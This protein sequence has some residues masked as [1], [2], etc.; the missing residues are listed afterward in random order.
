MDPTIDCIRHFAEPPEWDSGEMASIG[1]L[2]RSP[3]RQPLG[4]TVLESR[5]A[6]TPCWTYPRRKPHHPHPQNEAMKTNYAAH[7]AIYEA[8][9]AAGKP[10]WQEPQ[11]LRDTLA[12]L[13]ERMGSEHAPRSGRVLELGCGAGD[14]SLTLAEDGYE[15]HGVD[16]APTAI[17]W[18]RE[19]AAARC[20]SAHF[21]VGSVLEFAGLRE[22]FF[23][24]VLDGYCFHCIIGPDRARFLASARRAL[25]PGGVLHVATMCGEVTSDAL[26]SVLDPAS[27]CDLDSDGEATRYNGLPEASRREIEASGFRVLASRSDREGTSSGT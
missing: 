23:D 25:K 2:G 12:S 24:L 22:G 9:R 18:A 3:H 19:K 11:S 21:Q 27:R 26:R 14:L 10:G 8:R 17:D 7:D 13:A 6:R 4:G 1:S 16:I 5:W 15:V 20:L